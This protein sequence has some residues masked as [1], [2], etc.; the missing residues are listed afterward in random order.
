MKS[1]YR[2]GK[3]LHIKIGEDDIDYDEQFRLYFQT[4]LSNP[5]YKPEIAAQCTIINFTVTQKGLEDQLLAI[6][7]SEEEPDLE[8]TKNQLVQAFN[9]YKVQLKKLEDQLL[10]RLANAPEDILSDIPLIEGL[11]ATKAAAKEIGEAIVEGKRTEIEINVAREIYRP[12][13]S[14]GAMLYFLLTK[15][16]TIEHMYQYSLDMFVM[17]FYKSI[18]RALPAEKLPE[19]CMNLKSCLRI[20]IYTMVCRGL[21]VRHKLIFLAQ[22]TF[23]LMKRG[24]LGDDHILNDTYFQFLLR[25][26][27]K[28][29]EDNPLSTWLPAS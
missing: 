11:E 23:N 26:P 3:N 25:G 15:L 5:H 13:A 21:F 18:E 24:N 28:D 4:K 2:K 12:V 19:R 1:V 6:I 9:D 22:L 20:T 8:E 29:G 16:C 14:E 17:Y 10:E 27:R 7:V